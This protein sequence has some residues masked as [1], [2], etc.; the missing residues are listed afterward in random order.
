MVYLDPNVRFECLSKRG[1]PLHKAYNELGTPLGSN[2]AAVKASL[3]SSMIIINPGNRPLSAL[4]QKTRQRILAAEKAFKL[5]VE[6]LE[7]DR[8]KDNGPCLCRPYED[9]RSYGQNHEYLVAFEPTKDCIRL[10]EAYEA[11]G[12]EPGSPVAD[13][14]R[15]Y[16]ALAKVWHPDLQTGN[17]EKLFF[18]QE[19]KKINVSRE[20]LVSHL[21]G[22][23][24]QT[25]GRC[26][27]KPVP[28]ALK[29]TGSRE[30]EWC[31]HYRQ[32]LEAY[33]GSPRNKATTSRIQARACAFLMLQCYEEA[34]EDLDWLIQ[35]HPS[36]LE[37]YERRAMCMEKRGEYER[38][39]DDYN[40]L[41]ALAPSQSRYY[42]RRA[43][44]YNKLERYGLFFEDV[45]KAFELQT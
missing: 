18:E 35:T 36:Q 45:K 27:C 19:M 30:P 4:D 22:G 26:D 14:E 21:S 5:L 25:A 6:H 16:R 24:H 38:A 33:G 3:Q 23:D 28:R 31:K 15:R 20:L 10:H 8:H 39:I 7:S 29:H 43:A 12:L 11:I 37:N 1:N 44:V 41:I 34:T 32:T 13:V 2:K 42:V 40:T 17:D 9:I